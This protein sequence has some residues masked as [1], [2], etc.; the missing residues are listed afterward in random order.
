M[1]KNCQA[2]WKNCLEIIKEEVPEQS[3]K[4]WFAPIKPVKLQDNVLTIEVPTPFFYEWLEEHYVYIL[5]RAIDAELGPS[6]KLEYSIVVDKG[7]ANHQPFT[8]NVRNSKPAGNKPVV[9]THQSGGLPNNSFPPSPNNSG[10]ANSNSSN[11]FTSGANK[12][13]PISSPFELPDTDPAQFDTQLNPVY[14][15]DNYIEGDCNRLARSAG[16]AIAKKPGFTAFNPLVVYG[17]VGL[18]KTHLA[19]AIGNEIKASFPEKLV[20]YVTSDQ[21]TTQFIEA[22]KNNN[23][24]N[25]TNFYLK[26][27]VLIIDDIQF[28]AGKEKTQEN[29]FHIFNR[30]HQSGRQIIMTSD[31]PPR[32]LQGLQERLLSRFKWGLTADIQIPDY[33]TRVA[34]VQTKMSNEGVEVPNEVIEYLAR[35]VDSNIRELE[36]VLISLIANASFMRKDIDLELA[37]ITLLNIFR[38]TEKEITIEFIQQVVADYFKLSVEELKSKTRKKDIAS[39]RQ[40]AMYFSQ[41]YTDMPLKMIGDRFGGRDHSTVVHAS[42]TVIKKND[43]DAIYRKIINEL[44]EMMQVGK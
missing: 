23:V 22:L 27:D 10:N 2:I 5:K 28:L 33:E 19:Q 9:S 32:S 16:M 42:K 37:K 21:F 1:V 44:T 29:F 25:F 41:Q 34:I 13:K 35:N 14:T 43:N 4:T 31:C 36:G 30:L 20:L 40:I 6:G 38:T 17:G 3:F 18:G 15:F 11:N 12:L 8:L 39:A 24:Q 26:V 7:D